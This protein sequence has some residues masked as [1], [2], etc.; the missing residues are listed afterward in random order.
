VRECYSVAEEVGSGKSEY[1][2]GTRSVLAV[3]ELHKREFVEVE[4]EELAA[5]GIANLC[6]FGLVVEEVVEGTVELVSH[7]TSPISKTATLN[8]LQSHPWHQDR[9]P[10]PRVTV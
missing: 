6:S 3:G 10:N 4:A 7:S 9:Y 8:L 2:F 1:S 5:V